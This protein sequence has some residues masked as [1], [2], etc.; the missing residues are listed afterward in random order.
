MFEE[1]VLMGILKAGA[2]G[3]VWIKIK[4]QT[5]GAPASHTCHLCLRLPCH[6]RLATPLTL[7]WDQEGSSGSSAHQPPDRGA[8]GGGR[9]EGEEGLRES[10]G[11]GV[12]TTEPPRALGERRLY[13]LALRSQPEQR[14]RTQLRV[15]LNTQGKVCPKAREGAAPPT[16]GAEISQPGRHR[17]GGTARVTRPSEGQTS[18]L[19][20]GGGF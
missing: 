2:G 20:G 14:P 19:K 3:T 11:G 10:A 17:S 8:D 16:V 1:G 12:G 18:W 13:R 5:P 9:G 7:V 6:P 4:D 15:P